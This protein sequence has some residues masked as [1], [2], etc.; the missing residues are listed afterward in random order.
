MTQQLMRPFSLALEFG[1]G[2]LEPATGKVERRLS[3]MHGMYGNRQ[4]EDASLD[5][6]PLIYEVL[7]YDVPDENGQ[8]V[9]CTTILQP[10]RI[11]DEYYMTK[12][13]YHQKRDAGEVYL[14]LQG[15]G[16]LVMQAGEE[17]S[18]LDMQPGTI[19]YVPPF[20]A[21]RTVNVGNVP[22]I[23]L[24][25]YPADAGHDYGSIDRHGFSQ[26]VIERG[27]APTLVPTVAG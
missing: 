2:Q 5:A 12:G 6:N 1:S 24:A 13:H 19:A 8:L 18:Q 3:D 26:R 7:Q 25:V 14:G 27:G 9:V 4:A 21:H 23:F 17:F 20:W 22:F 15:R 10:G 11:G 16:K